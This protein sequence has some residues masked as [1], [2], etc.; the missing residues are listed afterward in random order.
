ML[1]SPPKIVL[2]ARWIFEELSGIGVYTRELIRQFSDLIEPDRIT[3]LFQ[4]ESLRD[5]TRE[6]TG[7]PFPAEIMPW[8]IFSP[9]GQ[10]LLPRRLRLLE[11]ELF[12]S[13]NYMIPM[14]AFPVR[15]AGPIRCVVTLHDLI[16]LVVPGYAPR[17]KKAKLKPVFIQIM[18]Q[19]IERADR[20]IAVSQSTQNDLINR[21]G[22][23]E[24][25]IDVVYNGVHDHFEPPPHEAPARRGLLYVGRSDPYKNLVLLIESFAR[26][27]AGRFPELTLRIVGPPDPRYPEPEQRAMDLGVREAITWNGYLSDAELVA[28]YQLAEVAVLPSSYEGFGLPVIEAMACGTPVVCSDRSSLPEIAGGA[29]EMFDLLDNTSLD[30]AI[31]RVL[32]N[33]PVRRELI[34]SG[35]ERARAFTWRKAA[36]ETLAS[37]R[38]A[39]TE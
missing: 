32:E 37:Y 11:A 10:I 3:L 28:A 27:R 6:E 30:A 39:C 33:E 38:V 9:K 35:L 20:I 31:A 19:V 8:G 7:F 14:R 29:A 16:P 4:S 34:R 2:D 17:S 1:D 26:L 25:R 13:P 12:H 18:R 5:R 21:L 24:Q 23:D 36:E 15:R 22:L